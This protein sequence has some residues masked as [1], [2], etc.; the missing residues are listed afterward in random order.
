MVADVPKRVPTICPASVAAL[1][2]LDLL[3]PQLA[4][5]IGSSRM[6]LAS[7]ALASARLRYPVGDVVGEPAGDAVEDHRQ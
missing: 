2:E 3:D 7:V 6:M 1:V 4:L 5:E